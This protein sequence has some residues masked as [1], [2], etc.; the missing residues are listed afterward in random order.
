M[1]PR[2][3]KAPAHFKTMAQVDVPQ[4]RNGKHKQIVSTILKD[5]DKSEGRFCHQ[6]ALGGFG[7]KQRE[8]T[9]SPES[10]NPE[11]W[12]DGCDRQRRQ[13][14]VRLER[15][16]SRQEP[17][18]L[19]PNLRVPLET[20]KVELCRGPSAWGS[21]QAAIP[22]LQLPSALQPEPSD[23]SAAPTLEFALHQ[24]G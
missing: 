16:R 14:P 12:A 7:G 2:T 13:L 1:S 11:S 6:S 20:A 5:L 19:K 21:S 9:F 3:D 23:I 22:R 4:G 15:Q 24:A 18:K 8:G 17:A 10:C